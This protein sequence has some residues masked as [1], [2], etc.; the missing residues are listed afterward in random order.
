MDSVRK[1]KIT[2]EISSVVWSKIN[3]LRDQ[4][5]YLNKPLEEWFK[6]ITR[7]VTLKMLSNEQMERSMRDHGML[8]LWMNNF[9]QNLPYIKGGDKTVLQ[10]PEGSETH[11]ISEIASPMPILEGEPNYVTEKDA[12]IG[13]I[14]G[15]NC[16]HP[17]KSA[18]LV[19]GRGPSVFKRNHLQILSDAIQKKEFTGQ[20][21]IPDGMLI[22]CLE[23]NIVPDFVI[24]VDGSP[25]IKK[26]FDHPLVYKHGKQLKAI[27]SVTV[28][29]EVY[30]FVKSQNVKIFWYEP[31][32]DDWRQNDS[33][34]RLQR[35]MT[36]SKK[37]PNGIPAAASGGNAGTC[38]FVMASTVLKLAPVGLIGIDLGYPEGTK[39]DET[40]YFSSYMQMN[41][42]NLDI[43]KQ[44]YEEVYHPFFKTRATIDHVFCNYRTAIIAMQKAN[45]PWYR[46]YGGTINCS[47]GG[48]LF[49]EGITCMWFKDFIAKY[50][51]RK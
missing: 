9:A 23:H 37:D 10:V 39:I 45:L 25:I 18:A 5:G 11:T 36:K 20:I 26:W 49:G 33:F 42:E 41:K 38:C 44:F 27:M 43:I 51:V 1:K 28:N 15:I 48:T 24:T 8:D 35:L 34:T 2:F 14:R 32:W 7:D 50:G 21:I 6:Y 47:E 30:R 4:Q 16:K 40:P 3:K 31:L 22:D 17:P 12:P 46:L 13:V 19:I 29:N